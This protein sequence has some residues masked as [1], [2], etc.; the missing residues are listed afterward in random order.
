MLGKRRRKKSKAGLTIAVTPVLA[1]RN[2]TSTLPRNLLH[3]LLWHVLTNVCVLGLRGQGDRR[4]RARMFVD[5]PL[6]APVPLVEQ[7]LRR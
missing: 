6:L 3:D 5:K 4:R 1:T 2:R 7:F